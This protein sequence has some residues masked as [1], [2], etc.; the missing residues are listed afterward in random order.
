MRLLAILPQAELDALVSELLPVKVLLGQEADDRTLVLREPGHVQFLPAVGVRVVCKADIRW[1]V[2]GFAV[3]IFIRELTVLLK[4]H[5]SAREGGMALVF[6]LSIE[7]ADLAGVPAVIDTRLVER[8]N[9]ALAERGVE[10]AWEFQK[11]LT[12]SFAL[13]AMLAN[14]RFFNL[15]VAESVVDITADAL[16]LALEL[17]AGITRE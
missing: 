5:I 6:D 3:P 15:D 1:S 4:P 17:R 8:V 12:H 7:H 10:L 11:T 14:L 2:L 13:P 16:R 9:Q